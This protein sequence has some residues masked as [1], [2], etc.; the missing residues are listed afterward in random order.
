MAFIWWRSFFSSEPPVIARL[1]RVI[2]DRDVF[3]AERLRPRGHLLDRVGAVGPV[4]LRLQIAAQV[5]V[6]DEAGSL[7]ASAASISPGLSRSSG[8]MHGRPRAA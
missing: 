1:A 6:V 7:P 8:A 5:A 4:G 3:E 2:G